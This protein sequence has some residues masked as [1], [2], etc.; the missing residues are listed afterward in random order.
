M[1]PVLGVVVL[2]GLTVYWRLPEL[3]PEAPD[4]TEIQFGPGTVS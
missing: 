3:D 2:F 4:V 1:E